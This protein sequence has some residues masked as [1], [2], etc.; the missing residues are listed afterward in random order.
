MNVHKKEFT[1]FDVAAAVRELKQ[2]I[3]GSRV[4]NVYQISQKAFL[5]K[6][7]LPDRP[8]F[9]LVLEAGKRMHLTAYV[10][11]KP[12]TPSAFCMSLRAFLRNARL[13]NIEQHEFER[14]VVLFLKS[15][16]GAL[17]LILEVFGDGNLILVSQEERILQALTYKRMRDRNVLRGEV[18]MFAP[19]SGKNPT[20][21]SFEEFSVGLGACG[22]VQVVRA[23]ARFLGIGGEYSEEVLMR[24]QVEKTKTCEALSGD[25]VK[26]IY[27]CIKEM[28][29]QVTTGTLE[30]CIV[31]GLDK[32]L[33]DVVPFKLVQHETQGFELQK[34]SSFNEALDEFY[35]RIF[36]AEKEAAGLD[37][38]A[39]RSEGER[40]KRIIAEQQ[41]LLTENEVSADTEKRVGDT[42][43][44]HVA[45]LQILLEKLL[46]AKQKGE[47]WKAVV[48]KIN[49][50]KKEGL[51]PSVLFESLDDKGSTVTVA[52]EDLRFGLNLNRNLYQNANQYYE[53]AKQTKL[54]M[55]GAEKAL[56]DSTSQ[57]ADLNIQMHKAEEIEHRASEDMLDGLATRKIKTKK[58]F[59]KFRWFV[60]SDG[61]LVV[62]GKDAVTNEVLVKKYAEKGDVVF[63]A[64]IVGAPFVVVKTET[65][66]PT[67]QCLREA[68]EFAAAYSRA[69][70]E[71]F[72]SVDVYW[73]KPDQL[74]K[75]APSGESVGHGAF[76]VRGQ[77]NWM[78]GIKLELAVG[79]V[80]DADD[81][82]HFVGG[83]MAAVKAKTQ[84][85][86]TVVPGDVSGKELLRF[87]LKALSGKVSKESGARISKA[88]IEDV[89]EYVPFGKGR[90]LEN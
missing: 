59:E 9:Q 3:L 38:E 84:V 37:I 62:A 23:L 17:K 28:L 83:P 75:E 85:Y 49:I 58:W 16:K 11:E 34:Y 12:P 14:V 81:L 45:E 46:G 78:R 82:F 89:R 66:E 79:T 63:H 30:P 76:V 22:D 5:L 18:F 87:I 21:L 4:S 27:D 7:H 8:P 15:R 42:I 52:I 71:G 26:A 67:G 13:A 54:K 31:L 19:S 47:N 57:L 90:L 53:K 55:E 24:A 88:S 69:W 50:E 72:G 61:C 40:L 36:I 70:R 35:T 29:T 25:D 32:S 6:L 80:I 10:I 43:Y 2:S 44:A 65:K 74:T 56:Q 60:S 20:G 48:N 68:G 39:L 33:L 77:R 86:V 41:K 51:T 73:V 64:D 1:S